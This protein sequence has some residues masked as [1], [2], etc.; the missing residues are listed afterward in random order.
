TGSRIYAPTANSI[1]VRLRFVA[2]LGMPWRER[3]VEHVIADA[4]PLGDTLGFI[5]R[6]MNAEI[7][8]ALAVLLL[9]LRERREVA[10]HQRTY[11]ALVVPR[12]AVQLIRNESE[13]DVV[14][15]I[16]APQNLEKRA[17][18]TGM[19]RRI[20]G[21]RWREVRSIEITGR[22]AERCK[23]R[24][25]HRVRIAVPDAGRAGSLVGFA[26]AG[27]RAPK[28]VIV[29]RF[30]DRGARVGERDVHQRHQ[31]RE[32]HSRR[33]HLLSDL[34]RDLVVEP[35]RR[36]QARCSIVGPVES[37]LRL[38]RR[39]GA[40]RYDAV[41][42]ERFY[43][44]IC[45]GVLATVERRR[46][47][48]AELIRRFEHEGCNLAPVSAERERT[49]ADRVLTPLSRIV[50]HDEID[51]DARL[52]M[53]RVIIRAQSQNC[54]GG[55]PSERNPTFL[56]AFV[57]RSN[58]LEILDEQII[59][60]GVLRRTQRGQC[61]V[62]RLRG[63][64]IHGPI[65]RH[66]RDAGVAVVPAGDSVHRVEDRDMND[67]HG[68]RGAAGSIL[69]PEDAVLSRRDGRVVEPARVDGDAV[70]VEKPAGQVGA[71]TPRMV[72]R[73]L[74]VGGGS[75]EAW[76]KLAADVAGGT[77]RPGGDGEK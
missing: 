45:G 71:A 63:C 64:R 8:A 10:R 60:A 74:T 35:R 53:L 24:I 13:D 36:A 55:A 18:E 70:P 31:P 73:R 48:N 77:V 20:R 76:S 3:A 39:A 44:L 12:H 62:R 49:V 33:T 26:D 67:R 40:R 1:L 58:L 46:R 34:H 50:A 43:F 17:A 21:K 27:D 29:L 38:F 9:R 47:R 15:A 30:P 57:A 19:S 52:G 72:P 28:I 65:L 59:E 22:R 51:V 16:E 68:A 25:A 69:L 66:P 23:V 37:D 11:L 61:V 32:L 2:P 56:G 41:A 6:P 4:P 54:R 42:A 75:A 7:D 5:E 14:G